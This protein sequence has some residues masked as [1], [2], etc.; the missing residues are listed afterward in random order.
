VCVCVCVF[1]CVCVCVCVRV[2][3]SP[4]LRGVAWDWAASHACISGH[5][6]EFHGLDLE[7][8]I[9]EHYYE[10]RVSLIAYC[11]A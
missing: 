7:M 9:N 1:V 2:C 8:A 3:V 10:A 5:L 6:T 4:I 11:I